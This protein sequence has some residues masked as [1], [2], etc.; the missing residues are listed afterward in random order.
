MMTLKQ[1]ICRQRGIGEFATFGQTHPAAGRVLSLYVLGEI[2][3]PCV[4]GQWRPLDGEKLGI[5]GVG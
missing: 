1:K 3:I 2:L 4:E 5:S